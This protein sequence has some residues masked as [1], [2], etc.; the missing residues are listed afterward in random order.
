MLCR[1]TIRVLLVAMALNLSVLPLQSQAGVILNSAEINLDV[2][3]PLGDHTIVNPTLPS[4]ATLTTSPEAGSLSSTFELTT[5]GPITS[6][7]MHSVSQFNDQHTAVI[8]NGF[9]AIFTTTTDAQYDLSGLLTPPLLRQVSVVLSG[10]L[11]DIADNQNLFV[12]SAFADGP[13]VPFELGDPLN[14]YLVFGA[15]TG[16]LKAGHSYDLRFAAGTNV[17]F[18][19]VDVEADT[20]MLFV[21]T[22]LPSTVPEP[23]SF[24]LLAIG[25]IGTVAGAWRRRHRSQRR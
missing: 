23:T 6:F 3:G 5:N 22:D 16:L 21:V 24:A 7:H 12:S 10:A 25:T 11:Y 20:E 14:S 19:P 15:R 13:T 4:S 9:H 8:Q 1:Q 18:N 2:I 17:V